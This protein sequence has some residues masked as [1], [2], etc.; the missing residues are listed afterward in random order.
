MPAKDFIK[1]E[2]VSIPTKPTKKEKKRR[3]SFKTNKSKKTKPEKEETDLK[4]KQKDSK[5]KLTMVSVLQS[6]D[7]SEFIDLA[8]TDSEED[9]KYLVL[10]DEEKLDIITYDK[11]ISQSEI[12]D[13]NINGN[14]NNATN[15]ATNSSNNNN[16]CNKN[17]I[18]PKEKKINQDSNAN[19]DSNVKEN[20][21]D[22]L[23]EFND[24]DNSTEFN[25]NDTTLIDDSPEKP[26]IHEKPES[27]DFSNIKT[28]SENQNTKS[29]VG[30]GI[31]TVDF[32]DRKQKFHHKE[33]LKKYERFL[34]SSPII[35][36]KFNEILSAES[37]RIRA[38]S[39]YLSNTKRKRKVYDF[40]DFDDL[41]EISDLYENEL[42]K[43]KEDKEEHKILSSKSTVISNLQKRE[44]DA[45]YHNNIDQIRSNKK[46]KLD[47]GLTTIENDIDQGVK[48]VMVPSFLISSIYY[49]LKNIFKF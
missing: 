28:I 10:E 8:Q 45:K 46:A 34:N 35:R 47:I 7:E 31:N 18:K 3:R 37:D 9:T 30:S 14:K 1:V 41:S 5:E 12:N 32:L 39:T 36:L 48:Y 22:N 21:C 29:I 24:D 26:K 19:K 23:T 43:R 17:I 40:D 20:N 33:K 6:S 49:S 15:N 4:K 27:L 2:K 16:N 44:E 38:K 11:Y 25:D 13:K 42:S